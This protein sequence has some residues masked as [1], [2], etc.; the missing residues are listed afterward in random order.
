MRITLLLLLLLLARPALALAPCP[1]SCHLSQGT[2]VFLSD[3]G[4]TLITRCDRT[5]K[6]G[7]LVDLTCVTERIDREGKVIET[8]PTPLSVDGDSQF[9]KTYL[10][11]HTIVEFSWQSRWTALGKPYVLNALFTH[12]KLELS[13]AKTKLTCKVPNQPAVVRDFGCTPHEIHVFA[14]TDGA[15]PPH[16]TIAIAVCQPTAVST[17]EVVVTCDGG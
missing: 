16:K 8:L 10:D 17:H 15:H 3:T 4:T 2:P 9:E 13:L 14:L 12:Q 7:K 5:T 1:T 11:G 6:A